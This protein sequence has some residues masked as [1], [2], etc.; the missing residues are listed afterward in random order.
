MCSAKKIEFEFFEFEKMH[1]AT[2]KINLSRIVYDLTERIID[3]VIYTITTL[4]IHI[5]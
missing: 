4:S 2:K 3:V 1:T 5:S